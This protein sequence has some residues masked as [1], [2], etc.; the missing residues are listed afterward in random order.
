[1]HIGSRRVPSH[2]APPVELLGLQA[3]ADT[4][5][6]DCIGDVSNVH[7]LVLG[8]HGLELMCA[9]IRRGCATVAVLRLNQKAEPGTADLVVV[10]RTASPEVVEQALRQAQRAMAPN[11]RIVLRIDNKRASSV[12]TSVTRLLH[13]LG[14]RSIRVRSL[15]RQTLL[16]AERSSSGAALCH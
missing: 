8:E 4:A 11:G 10:P 15:P 12:A 6:L 14:F 1:M 2:P 9:L 3:D 16:S 13:E 7:A 5:M